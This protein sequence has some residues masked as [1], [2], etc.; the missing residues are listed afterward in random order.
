MTKAKTHSLIG[1]VLRVNW[2]TLK[3]ERLIISPQRFPASAPSRLGLK[4]FAP[5]ADD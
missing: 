2:F 1:Q 3:Y 4:H 5:R